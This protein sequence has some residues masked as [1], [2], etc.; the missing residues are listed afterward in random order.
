MRPLLA[1]L[2]LVGLAAGQTPPDEDAEPSKHPARAEV[3][4]RRQQLRAG[5]P[6]G[7]TGPT[8][9][10]APGGAAPLPAAPR[11]QP[12]P[13]PAHAK[14]TIVFSECVQKLVAVRVTLCYRPR[15]A[16]AI[17]DGIV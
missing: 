17:V 14:Q 8:G 16:V 6:V 2:L 9:E 3:V 5:V 12:P 1:M 10:A 13:R 7:P 15:S 4:S 11:P